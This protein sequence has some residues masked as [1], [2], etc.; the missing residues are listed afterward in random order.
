MRPTRPIASC[1]VAE[2]NCASR[3]TAPRSARLIFR[4]TMPSSVMALSSFCLQGR[5]KTWIDAPRIAFA[6]LRAVLAAEILCRLDIALRIVVVEAGFRID[7]A[8]GADHLAG[9]QDIVDRN[10]PRQQIDARLVIDA[11][12]EEHVLEEVLA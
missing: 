3:S 11:S 4:L 7:P 12:I 5:I 9:E 1:T 6:Y 8:H 2:P 10:D